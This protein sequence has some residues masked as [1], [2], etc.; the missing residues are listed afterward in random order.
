MAV[1]GVW[2]ALAPTGRAAG[3]LTAGMARFEITPEPAMTNWATHKPYG[4]ILDPLYVRALVLAQGTQKVALIFWDLLDVR[5]SATARLRPGIAPAIGT[6][7]SHILICA[8]H[9]HSAPFSPI[10]GDPLIKTEQKILAPTLADPAFKAWSARLFELSLKAAKEADASRR[11]A[12]LAIGRGF[13]GEVIFNRRPVR[14]DG[15]VETIYEPANPHALPDGLRFGPMD[16]TLTVLTLRDPQERVMAT[17]FNLP[18]HAVAIY[19]HYPGISGDWPGAVAAG[20]QREQG[21]EALC[22]PGCAGEIVPARRGTAARDQM[23]KVIVERAVAAAKLDHLIQGPNGLSAE[24]ASLELPLTE[25]AR[26]DLGWDHF[27]AEVQVIVLGSL[28]LVALPGEP[29]IEV[30]KAIQQGSPFPHT[31]VLG[32]ANGTG[33]QY[34]GPAGE[35]ARGGYEMGEFGFGTDAC[36][37]L[38]IDTAIRLLNA[39]HRNQSP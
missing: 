1:L 23:A 33:V 24:T 7:E 4:E 36:G 27:R 34:V 21:G 35:K 6:P 14:E 13:A 39:R 22:L 18:C 37:T 3:A 19:S 12:T 2:L 5:E 10:Q 28:A 26:R 31:I 20:L 16:P 38:L 25:A 30:A 9:N 32:Y 29:L 15:T 8:T 17:L 11:P